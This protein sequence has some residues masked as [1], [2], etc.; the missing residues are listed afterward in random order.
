MAR[1]RGGRITTKRSVFGMLGYDT[2]EMIFARVEPDSI[3][4]ESLTCSQFST[5]RPAGGFQ[6][7]V[8]AMNQ[9]PAMFAW[10]TSLGCPLLQ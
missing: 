5:L 7:D 2:L 1:T 9:T 10:A 8:L 3:P 6:T 4:V